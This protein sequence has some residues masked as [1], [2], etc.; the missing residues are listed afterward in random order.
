MFYLGWTPHDVEGQG[1]LFSGSEE[2]K[3]AAL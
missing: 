1:S 3:H 2:G